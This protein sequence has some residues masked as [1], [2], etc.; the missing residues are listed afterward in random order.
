MRASDWVVDLGPG[1]GE[2]GGEIVGEG[3][4]ETIA[5]TPGLG[6]GGIPERQAPDPRPAEARGRRARLV[7]G[8]WRD[9]AQPEGHRRRLPGR[10]VHRRDRCLGLG[11][12][13]ARE[14]DPLQV[15][16]EPAEQD[17]D[18]AGRPRVR[19]R[20]R[21]LRQGHRD[22]P[23]PDRP[24]SALQPG[25]LH[26]SLHPCARALL[27]DARG[28]DPRLQARS[29]L[30]Q[31]PRRP[32]RGVQGRRDDQDRDALPA[33]RLRPVRDLPRAAVQQGDARGALQ[34]EGDRGCA[35]DVGRGGARLL[36][37]DPEDPA[38]PADAARRRARLH[39]ARPAGDDALGR[40]GA[41]REARRPS[42]RRSRPGRRSTSSTSRRPVSTSPTSR[43]CSR[44]SSG[45]STT[46]TRCS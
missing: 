26:R 33:R 41:A 29:L 7:L 8:P 10:T 32:L 44:C 31:R 42:S 14:R 36:R 17:A 24:H 5:D 3:L 45:S 35:R 38:A 13:H 15:A 22:R 28:E 40:R 37:E 20:D 43:S 1:A 18:E 34:G 23:E 46:A 2:H 27:A 25:D 4:A 6:H 19:R 21:R 16:R 11:E 9:D 12:V 39:Q 30:V